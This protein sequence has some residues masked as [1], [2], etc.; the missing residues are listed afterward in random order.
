MRTTSLAVCEG[1]GGDALLECTRTG[2][3]VCDDCGVIASAGG[4]Y[5]RM[6]HVDTGTHAGF[7]LD[8]NADLE[9]ERELEAELGPAVRISPASLARIQG[10]IVDLASNRFPELKAAVR[11]VVDDTNF[12]VHIHAR[13]RTMDQ[14]YVAVVAIAY[15]C[16][17]RSGC[18][19]SL[20]DIC[21]ASG[22]PL[23][24]VAKEVARIEKV[25]GM[26]E[27]VLD[28]VD[29]FNAAR[30]AVLSMYTG[31]MTE[32]RRTGWMR[33]MTQKMRVFFDKWSGDNRYVNY[34][35]R[36]Q[37]YIAIDA[38]RD[39]KEGEEFFVPIPEHVR[40]TRSFRKG[41]KLFKPVPPE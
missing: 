26:D 37:V 19:E 23:L 34:P 15:I 21:K 9:L 36:T 18:T 13:I 40:K 28:T 24:F 11:G 1:C 22:I 17:R 30:L 5:T 7:A 41:V 38:V 12:K 25:L 35:P 16:R 6:S 10:K 31:R 33:R 29:A 32:K 39:H 27:L 20:Y 8:A 3:V 14:V 4:V 2:D